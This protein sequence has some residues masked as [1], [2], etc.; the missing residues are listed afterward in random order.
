MVS[1]EMTVTAENGGDRTSSGSVYP[2]P[3]GARIPTHDRRHWEIAEFLEEESALLD[4][5]DLQGWLDLLAGDIVYRAPVRVTRQ[6][7]TRGPFETDM[8]HFNENAMTLMLKIMRLTQ[9]E[10]AWSENPAS[11]THRIVHKVRAYETAASDEYEVHS[12]VVLLRSRYDDPGLETLTA[13]RVDVIRSG[14]PWEIASRTLYF[15]QATLGVQNL[16]VYL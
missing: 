8:Y 11:R 2:K 10:S 3:T 4:D 6:A 5:D 7:G 9:T 12:S 16:A 15:D 14:D 13:R 1:A